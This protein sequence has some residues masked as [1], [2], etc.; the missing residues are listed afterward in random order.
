VVCPALVC[1]RGAGGFARKP[2][3]RPARVSRK[4]LPNSV[5]APLPR[6]HLWLNSF[7]SAAAT[8]FTISMAMVS[9]PTPPGTGE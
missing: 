5:A 6:V 2:T 1:H 3:A 8:V 9:G 4:I 7:F